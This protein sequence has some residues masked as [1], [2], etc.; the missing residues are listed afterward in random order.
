ML[1]PAFF[2]SRGRP[3]R[4]YRLFYQSVD[5]RVI[6][7]DY[8]LIFFIVCA[9][10]WKLRSSRRSTAR[11]WMPCRCMLTVSGNGTVS[12][13]RTRSVS[14]RIYRLIGVC[15]TLTLHSSAV[16][17]VTDRCTS[18]HDMS[19]RFEQPHVSHRM[20][21]HVLSYGRIM[22][23]PRRWKRRARLYQLSRALRRVSHACRRSATVRILVVFHC[24]YLH[25]CVSTVSH[26]HLLFIRI[27]A[28]GSAWCTLYNRGSTV[29]LWSDHEPMCCCCFNGNYSQTRTAVC[30]Y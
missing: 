26:P 27:P 23:R 18:P 6:N 15:N 29:Q 2:L 8:F 10:Q 11:F 20:P 4:L 19:F 16:C 7:S 13:S 21:S 3:P 14:R 28:T 25:V 30:V 12:S 9:A 24:I 5:H 1:V 22:S 17:I